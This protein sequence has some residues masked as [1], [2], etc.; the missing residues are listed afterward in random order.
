MFFDMP[1]PTVLGAPE[2]DGIIEGLPM[3]S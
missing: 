2:W 3:P 1:P